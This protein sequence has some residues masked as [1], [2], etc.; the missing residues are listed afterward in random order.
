MRGGALRRRIT[1]QTR[2]TAR[3]DYG[4]RS[5]IWTDYMTDIPADI[6]PLTGHALEVARAIYSEVSHLIPIRYSDR[7]ADPAFV[8]T[9]RAVYKN[10]G[11]TR[12]FNIGHAVN[13]EERNREINLYT[14]EGLNLG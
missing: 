6:N 11:V 8:A 14:S 9:M 2:S 10:G 13:V 4:Q 3:D 7:L 12:Y 5:E 1:L